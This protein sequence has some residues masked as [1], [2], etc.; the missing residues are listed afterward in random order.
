MV[1]PPF[2]PMVEVPLADAV[3]SDAGDTGSIDDGKPQEAW[4]KLPESMFYS[5]MA[6]EPEVNPLYEKAKS[7]SD[8]WVAKVLQMDELKAYEWKKMDI[9]YMGAICA[10]RADLET[11]K[12]INDWNGWVFAFDDPFDREQYTNDP[13]RATEEVVRTLMV[14]DDV[15]PVVTAEENPVRHILQSCWLRFKERA[16]PSLQYRW[17]QQLVIY[18]LGVLRQVDFQRTFYR[19]TIHE[20][21][22]YRAGCVGAYPCLGLMELAE[23]IDLPQHV[24]DHPSLQSISRVSVDLVTLQNDLCSYK[25]DLK[26][27]ENI[28]IMFILKDDGLSDQEAVDR[29]GEMLRDCYKRWYRAMTE[30]PYWGYKIDKHVLRYIE[31]C[32]NLAL[33]NLTWSLYTPRYM[34]NNG[35]E[36]R[37]TRMFRL[38]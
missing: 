9:A 3:P 27:G 7:M 35:R 29:V 4:V 23:D 15:H 16:S 36:V 26:Q 6:S 11:L 34:G 33:G 19:P 5:I 20:Y 25:K 8:E 28:N 24:L 21:M 30:L 22:D 10:P 38:D 2:T 13:F 32:R 14:L 17:K 31:G 18:C 12:L 37:E 1:N